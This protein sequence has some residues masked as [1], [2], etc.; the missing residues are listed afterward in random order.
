[1]SR[2]VPE[3]QACDSSDPKTE[4]QPEQSHLTWSEGE[5]SPDDPM[6]STL[7]LAFGPLPEEST[8]DA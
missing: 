7:F 3:D 2:R 1:M 8:S 5:A 4:Q 6:F